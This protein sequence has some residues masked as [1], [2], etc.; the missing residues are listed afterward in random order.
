MQLCD[1]A[2]FVGRLIATVEAALG[3][4]A[5]LD[6]CPACIGGWLCSYMSPECSEPCQEYN[7]TGRVHRDRRSALASL[8][9]T[10]VKPERT[11]P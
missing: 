1:L 4:V 7:G 2:A 6:K 9:L 10:P 8:Q 3:R 5:E 11:G